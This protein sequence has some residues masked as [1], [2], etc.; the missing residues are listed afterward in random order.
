MK[1]T[2]T[3]VTMALLGLGTVAVNAQDSAHVSKTAVHTHKRVRSHTYVA[4]HTAAAHSSANTDGSGR[5]SSTHVSVRKDSAP[6]HVHTA[7]R[8]VKKS[9]NQ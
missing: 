6:G 2:I 3:L 4:H 9:V 5:Y 1:K 7:K 8:V